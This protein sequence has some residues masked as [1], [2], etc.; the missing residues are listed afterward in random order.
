[1]GFTW[2]F[3]PFRYFNKRIEAHF[4]VRTIDWSSNSLAPDCMGQHGEKGKLH[5]IFHIR[6]WNV[7]RVDTWTNIEF[8]V[9]VSFVFSL[10]WLKLAYHL[11]FYEEHFYF[12]RVYVNIETFLSTS[13]LQSPMELK[14]QIQTPNT[15][16][17]QNMHTVLSE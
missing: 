3:L 2:H 8:Y 4:E 11:W 9:R 16:T 17:A 1:M 14:L 5:E 15:V 7:S 10:F 6:S 12:N 13:S